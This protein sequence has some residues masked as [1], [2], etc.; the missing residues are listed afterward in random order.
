MLNR[1]IAKGEDVVEVLAGFGLAY[2]FVKFFVGVL[3]EAKQAG[4]VLVHDRRTFFKIFACFL[5]CGVVVFVSLVITGEKC[6]LLL[7]A[8]TNSV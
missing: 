6:G 7:L 8:T 5:V 4:L 2:V 3:G 1:S